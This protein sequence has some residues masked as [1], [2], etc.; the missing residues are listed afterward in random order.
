MH[1]ANECF[2]VLT[3]KG[4]ILNGIIL[5]S[6][7]IQNKCMV[8]TMVANFTVR[9]RIFTFLLEFLNESFIIFYI[10]TQIKCTENSTPFS[11]LCIN[12]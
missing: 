5:K 7:L 6:M 8:F 4:S 12:F 3:Q 9:P 10:K 1:G 11:K 2:S